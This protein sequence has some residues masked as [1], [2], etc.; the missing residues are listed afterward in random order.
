MVERILTAPPVRKR[1]ACASLFRVAAQ[2]QLARMFVCAVP[3]AVV[4]LLP[5][6]DL[7]PGAALGLGE[8]QRQ[9]SAIDRV[10]ARAIDGRNA[11]AGT[12]RNCPRPRNATDLRQSVVVVLFV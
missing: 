7:E 1:G 2:D 4:R 8:E 12:D 10:V 6:I 9:F 5:A 11:R 3:D